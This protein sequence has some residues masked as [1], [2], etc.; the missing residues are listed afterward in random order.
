PELIAAIEARTEYRFLYRDALVAGVRISLE[1]D[2]EHWQ[3]D[4]T[5]ILAETGIGMRVDEVGKQVVLYAGAPLATERQPTQYRG[6]VLDAA[7][8]ARLPYATVMWP[9]RGLWR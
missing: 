5:Q 9:E 7:T 8:G 4:L 2:A 6:V 3:T 1:T